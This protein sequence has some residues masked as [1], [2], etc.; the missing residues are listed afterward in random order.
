MKIFQFLYLIYLFNPILQVQNVI[1]VIES[2][3]Q[4]WNGLCTPM[5]FVSTSLRTILCCQGIPTHFALLAWSSCW[6]LFYVCQQLPSLHTCRWGNPTSVDFLPLP[7]MMF[8]PPAMIMPLP[9]SSIPTTSVRLLSL[10]VLICDFSPQDA[11][12][13]H[14]C[15]ALLSCKNCTSIC[16]GQVSNQQQSLLHIADC[17]W[18]SVCGAAREA[19]T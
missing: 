5:Y 16:N 1:H 17:R 15:A 9:W 2:D 10:P 13:E 19:C 6:F 8:P 4:L 3:F 7:S 14:G 18:S 12:S 11:V